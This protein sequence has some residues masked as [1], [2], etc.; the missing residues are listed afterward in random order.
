MSASDVLLTH[1]G[2]N[3]NSRNTKNFVTIMNSNDTYIQRREKTGR[4][5]KIMNG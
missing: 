2:A 3:K 5:P 1:L 4:N